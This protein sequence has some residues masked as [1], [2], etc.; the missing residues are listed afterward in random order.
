MGS[1]SYLGD[2]TLAASPRSVRTHLL[3]TIKLSALPSPTLA[4][5][6][7]AGDLSCFLPSHAEMFCSLK[8]VAAEHDAL[9]ASHPFVRNTFPYNVR[10]FPLQDTCSQPRIIP[11]TWS[12]GRLS[13]PVARRLELDD[14]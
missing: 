14:L 1:G 3:T 5:R 11:A 10:R 6:R 13:L 9:N 2:N 8:M 4:A 7:G 12:R